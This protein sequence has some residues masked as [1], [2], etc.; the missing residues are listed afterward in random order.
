MYINY[1]I[2]L[3]AA[4]LLHI[5]SAK[6]LHRSLSFR[7]FLAKTAVVL[8]CCKTTAVLYANMACTFCTGVAASEY[9]Q[10][11]CHDLTGTY[12]RLPAFFQGYLS[13][14]NYSL[15]TD[16]ILLWIVVSRNPAD[17]LR[18]KDSNIRKISRFEKTT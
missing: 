3:Y 15:D 17:G 5:K 9:M 10:L 11:S 7:F 2:Y 8:H 1:T 6:N 4:I 13:I 14:Y 18:I 16:G 12:I